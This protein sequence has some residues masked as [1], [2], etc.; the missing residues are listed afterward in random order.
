VGGTKSF[1]IDHPLDPS[2]K[3]LLH[4]CVESNKQ[5]NMYSGNVV[6]DSDGEATV[7]L[8]SYFETLNIDF[9][10]QLTVINEF[11]QAI[12]S[13][14]I[15]SNQFKIKTNKPNVEVSWLVMGTR[16]DAWCKDHPFNDEEEKIKGEKGYYIYPEG[17]G[18]PKE[19]SID[20]QKDVKTNSG[21]AFREEVKKEE[22]IQK[23]KQGA[24]KPADKK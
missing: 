3:Y 6:T 16:N 11:S 18:L 22:A 2:N 10:Y 8:P 13:Q 4:S 15:K 19:M 24:V 14:K 9:R 20:Y 23:S 21:E 17:F 5:L 7:S 12:I 1:R